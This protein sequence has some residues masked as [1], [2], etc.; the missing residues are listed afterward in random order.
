VAEGQFGA[1]NPQDMRPAYHITSA[2][3]ISWP[4]DP[5][6]AIFW[7]GRY[8]LMW[9]AKINGRRDGWE[10]ASSS[11]LIHWKMHPKKYLFYFSG[12]AFVNM[13]GE[14]NIV[15]GGIDRPSILSAVATDDN[16]DQWKLISEK[17]GFEEGDPDSEMFEIWDPCGWHDGDDFYAILGTFQHRSKPASVWKSDIMC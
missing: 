9:I 1:S 10:Y 2:D 6:G 5:N 15:C 11:D 8:H 12:N 17:T 4:F 16:L 3:Q 14:A 13:N 7:K